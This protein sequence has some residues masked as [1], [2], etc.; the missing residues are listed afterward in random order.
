MEKGVQVMILCFV[1]LLLF[2]YSGM[3]TM[4][5]I[6][7][8]CYKNFF[9]NVRFSSS[10]NRKAKSLLPQQHHQ[11]LIYVGILSKGPTQ[12]LRHLLSRRKLVRQI[13]A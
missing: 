7:A 8:A 4:T 9:K 12:T 6:S 3:V 2:H 11:Q 10:T 13:L 5:T 1:M